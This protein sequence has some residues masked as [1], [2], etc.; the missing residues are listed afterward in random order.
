MTAH[1]EVAASVRAMKAGAVDFL[2]KPFERQT[3]FDALERAL[4]RDA[5]QRR[6]RAEAEHL[7]ALFATLSPREQEV[8]DRVVAG[9]LNKQIADEL[10]VSE[11]TVKSQRALLMDK[12]G[13]GSPAELG[14]LVER[15]RNLPRA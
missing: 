15:L 10:G 4:A 1:P 11:R 9:K 13:A 2:E 12:L 8:L 6:A 7:R 3:L 14:A 5:S